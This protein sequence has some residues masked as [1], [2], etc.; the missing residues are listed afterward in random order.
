MLSPEITPRRPIARPSARRKRRR[1]ERAPPLRVGRLAA[2]TERGDTGRAMSQQNVEIVRQ[3][4]DA[5]ARRDNQAAMAFYDPQVEIFGEMD[6][7]IYRG[8]DG[9][10]EYFRDWLGVWDEFGSEVEEW[11]DTGEHVIAVVHA[12]GRGK[13]S[14]AA[15]ERREA[16]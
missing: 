12:W 10:R 4:H 16:H 6:G 13:Q 15:V 3:A 8:L 5:F 14:R 7:R 11:I 2:A 9:V 1:A